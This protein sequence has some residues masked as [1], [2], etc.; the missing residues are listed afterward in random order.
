MGARTLVMTL[1]L[2]HN[3]KVSEEKI[4][5]IFKVAAVV[6]ASRNGIAVSISKAVLPFA[7][8]PHPRS[9]PRNV[10][11][12]PVEMYGG[13]HNPQHPPAQ[14]TATSWATT[15]PSAMPSTVTDESMVAWQAGAFPPESRTDPRASS[16]GADSY[17]LP[18]ATN[19]FSALYPLEPPVLPSHAHL[20]PNIHAATAP[21]A[22]NTASVFDHGSD[23]GIY[24]HSF[25][26]SSSSSLSSHWCSQTSNG[27]RSAA[28]QLVQSL[29]RDLGDTQHTLVQAKAEVNSNSSGKV[30]APR[31]RAVA[32]AGSVAP[33]VDA[34]PAA[35]PSPGPTLRAASP[36]PASR[37]A[38]PGHASRSRSP[39]PAPRTPS[40]RPATRYSSPVPTHISASPAS[41]AS[42]CRPTQAQL[43]TVSRGTT[44]IETC[45]GS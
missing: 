7:S 6:A 31:P 32:V 11:D 3:V 41:P 12:V 16:V 40:C 42:V 10:H 13:W 35:F 33:R 34:S 9:T 39:S 14:F 8:L 17:S 36:G 27:A 29:E 21:D 5:P 45:K 19:T 15:D 38:S 26:A 2:E 1:R 37:P 44:S 4:R 23:L 25:A 22:W 30:R 43:E 18:L 20:Y 24:E 28:Q